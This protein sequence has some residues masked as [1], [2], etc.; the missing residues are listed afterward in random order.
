[1]RGNSLVTK[2]GLCN[3]MTGNNGET[4]C[5]NCETLIDF[6]KGLVGEEIKVEKNIVRIEKS[7]VE[8]RKLFS[9]IALFFDKDYHGHSD[10]SYMEIKDIVEF[11]GKSTKKEIA[12]LMNK[13][14]IAK[15]ILKKVKEKILEHE[16]ELEGE[17]IRKR[18]DRREIKEKA[19]KKVFGKLKTKRLPI[20]NE[21]RDAIFD[22]FSNE[23]AICGANEGLHIHHKDHNPKNNQISN[24]IVLCGV[25]HKKIHMKVR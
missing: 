5:E 14:E 24:L 3:S 9:N 23:C 2:C 12:E 16:I 20:S 22:K 17:R 7:Y 21:E 13:K 25:C 10:S 18:K 11:D 8:D 1:M 6:Y 4:Y 19:E 15:N